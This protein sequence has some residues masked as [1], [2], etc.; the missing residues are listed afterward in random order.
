MNKTQL[1]RYINKYALGGEIKSVKRINN[2][3]KL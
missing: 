1:I 2:G 3:R